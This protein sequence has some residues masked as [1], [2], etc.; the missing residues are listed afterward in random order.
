MNTGQWPR[1]EQ[2]A[3]PL[4]AARTQFGNE[5][6]T[7]PTTQIAHAPDPVEVISTAPQPLDA[8]QPAAPFMP[9]QP[10]APVAAPQQAAPVAPLQPAASVE[11]VQPAAPVASPQIDLTTLQANL[12]ALDD[13]RLL[14]V[15]VQLPAYQLVRALECLL[16]PLEAA[17]AAPQT[18]PAA[19]DPADGRVADRTRMLRAGKIIYNNKMSVSDCSIR[20]LSST[21]CRVGLESLV[22]IPDH[23]T[24]HIQNGGSRHECEVVWRKS[25]MMGVKF[26]G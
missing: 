8:S 15:L 23:F 22:G 14:M 5:Q 16:K 4:E 11:P 26:I 10:A 1:D 24:L 13:D 20:D 21:G 9:S 25:D 3:Q 12:V 18:Q 2:P 6:G 19:A 7:I 17:S